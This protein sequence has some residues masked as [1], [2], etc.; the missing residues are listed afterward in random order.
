MAYTPSLTVEPFLFS[1]TIS[2]HSI[3]ILLDSG[4]IANFISHSFLAKH[5]SLSQKIQT[6]FSLE[7]ISLANGTTLPCDKPIGPLRLQVNTYKDLL[8]FIPIQLHHYDVILGTP[9]LIHYNL[10]IDWSEITLFFSHL[11]QLH[12]ICAQE[13]MLQSF[14]DH[15]LVLS[16]MQFKRLVR[17]QDLNIF[18]AILK[19]ISDDITPAQTLAPAQPPKII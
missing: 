6:S 5:S 12:G 4:A 18:V 3:T 2:G 14:V 7:I 16:A 1:G 11:G 17:K 13:S 10:A 15:P 8:H 19:P 9:W